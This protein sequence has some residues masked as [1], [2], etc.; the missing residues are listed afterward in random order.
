MLLPEIGISTDIELFIAMD[1]ELQL[2]F[3]IVV[4]ENGDAA[5]V[6]HGL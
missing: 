1:L 6:K 3:Y 4:G 5:S 2:G